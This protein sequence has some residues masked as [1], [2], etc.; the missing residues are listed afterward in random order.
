MNPIYCKYSNDRA[1]RFRIKT[2][3]REEADGERAVYKYALD[4]R[5]AE[6]V[7]G[8]YG[9]YLQ[10]EESYAGSLFVPNRCERVPGGVKIEIVE[11][12]TLEA[13]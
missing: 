1:E 7:D 12:E 5:A 4:S 13:C 6:H 10:F 8:M 9:H 2:V 11:G 3:I